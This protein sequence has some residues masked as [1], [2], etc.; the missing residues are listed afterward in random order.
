LT[1]ICAAAGVDQRVTHE[2]AA[3]QLRAEQCRAGPVGGHHGVPGI[4]RHGR[5]GLVGGQQPLDCGPVGRQIL[6]GQLG[7][8]VGRGPPGGVQ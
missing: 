2:V 1:I 5:I 7:V 6:A 8:R 4:Q 3:G